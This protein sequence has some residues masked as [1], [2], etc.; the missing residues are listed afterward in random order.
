MEIVGVCRVRTLAAAVAPLA[1]ALRRRLP[2]ARCLL[3]QPASLVLPISRLF[4]PTLVRITRSNNIC[5]DQALYTARL[6]AWSDQ[7]FWRQEGTFEISENL[8]VFYLV[9][10]FFR[11]GWC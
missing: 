1:A 5:A 9:A 7:P 6:F 4:S 3:I 2:T 10:L 8:T 11:A